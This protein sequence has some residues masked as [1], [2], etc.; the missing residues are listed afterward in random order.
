LGE[1]LKLLVGRRTALCLNIGQNVAR[2]VAA[3]QLQLPDQLVL[4]P[5][6][7]VAELDYASPNHVCVS[8]TGAIA[9]VF[10]VK[11]GATIRPIGIW[12]G[13]V[14]AGKVL[15]KVAIA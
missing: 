8:R 2:H 14:V 10:R 1:K 6:A 5:A 15:P 3:Q 7:L 13:M 9:H 4:R 11:A 12:H